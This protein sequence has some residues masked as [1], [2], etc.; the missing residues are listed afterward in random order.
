MNVQ[1]HRELPVTLIDERK[2]ELVEEYA[3]AGAKFSK[4]KA[5]H[6][7]VAAI[8]KAEMKQI[9]ARKEE[10]AATVLAGTEMRDVTCEE[11]QILELSTVHL[12][13]IDTEE[14]IDEW[15][16]TS[17]DL[18]GEL[19]LDGEPTEGLDTEADPEPQ[20]FKLGEAIVARTGDKENTTEV[21]G[22][23][24]GIDQDGMVLLRELD[25]TRAAYNPAICDLY[26]APDTPDET[27]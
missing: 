17:E 18:Q 14:V 27:A 2:I 23:F 26:Y 5:E 20:N 12:V 6:D 24:D 7:A 4:I 1:S 22:E 11:R 15:A 8:A 9:L 25:G 19:D 10:I 16:M 13:R 21:H 3:R